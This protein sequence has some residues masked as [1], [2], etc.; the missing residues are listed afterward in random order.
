VSLEPEVLVVPHFLSDVECDHLLHLVEGAWRPS[1]VSTR[2][3]VNVVDGLLHHQVS[4]GRTSWSCAT[5]YS[6]TSV[7]QRI[8]HRLASLAGLPVCQLE[9]LS[10]VRYAPGEQF[11]EHHDGR[12]RPRT[13][14]V[15]LNDLSEDDLGGDTF[16]PVLGLSF[17]PR[18]GAAVVWSNATP[19]GK[20]DSRMLHVG[21]APS[22]SVK[23]AVN[24]FFS[25]VTNRAIMCNPDFPLSDSTLV[26]VRDFDGEREGSAMVVCLLHEDPRVQAVP[27]FLEPSDIAHILQ[28]ISSPKRDPV[29]FT[30]SSF[31]GASEVI[32]V[33]EMGGTQTIQTVEARLSAI[34]HLPVD[35]LSQL[36]IV[37]P[38]T[39]QGLCDR[40]L[41]CISFYVCLSEHDEVFFPS[42]GLR[43]AL[44]SG[45][46]VVWPTAKM[47]EGQVH[48]DLRTVHF[49]IRDDL[50]TSLVRG[51]DASFY[52]E[53]FRPSFLQKDRQFAAD[54]IF[55][56]P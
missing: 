10:L 44:H 48:E 34:A 40:G 36:R 47:V 11:E 7:L 33:L 26:N 41:G 54:A 29:G 9:K 31:L 30:K 50:S 53:A 12:D 24:C 37:Q 14:F 13:I 52:G 5:R 25:S 43:I 42:L 49:H 21:R 22:L 27:G 2:K 17:K 38:G 51:L 6:Q 19:E 16:F 23:Y 39:R 20:A 55:S 45:D 32:Q 18:R 28:H 56:K 1:Q 35:H 4:T 3:G 8:E 46:A 15:Y